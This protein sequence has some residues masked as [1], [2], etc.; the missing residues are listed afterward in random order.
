ML[1]EMVLDAFPCLGC[2]LGVRANA[3]HPEQG[4]QDLRPFLGVV[5]KRVPGGGELLD[6]VL[7][8][9]FVQHRA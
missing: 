9:E 2:G 3:H 6:V 5:Q 4:K 7:H 1:G 8:P